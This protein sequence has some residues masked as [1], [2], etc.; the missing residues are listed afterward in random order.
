[1]EKLTKLNS[2]SGEL[3][4]VLQGLVDSEDVVSK[5]MVEILRLVS[6]KCSTTVN[7]L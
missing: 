6:V 3:F 7:L 4:G 1:M 2:E 5:G